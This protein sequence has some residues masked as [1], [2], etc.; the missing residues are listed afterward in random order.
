MSEQNT[1]DGTLIEV[2]FGSDHVQNTV[3]EQYRQLIADHDPEDVL[4]VAGSP[5]SM[6]T[7]ETLLGPELPGAAVPRVTSL[8]VHATD[9]INRTDDRA[10]L[11]DAMRRELVH[12]FLDDRD[13]ESDYL[14]RAAEQDSFEADFAQLMETAVWQ[15][16]EF[17]TTP[18]LRAVTGAVDEFHAWLDEHDHLERGELITKALTALSDDDTDDS[19]HDGEAV[20]VVE[21]EEFLEQ[22][23]EYLEAL[24]ADRQLVCIAERDASIRRAWVEPGPITERVS[25]T[26]ER[27]VEGSSPETRPGATARYLACEESGSDPGE[28]GV[29]VIAA[30]TANAEIERIA[31]EIERLRD[32]RGWEYEQF[33][34]A[35]KR[36][37][38][39][40]IDTLRELKQ[41]GIPTESATVVGFGDDPAIRELLQVVRALAETDDDGPAITVT[42]QPLDADRREELA[43]MDDLGDALRR[44][45]TASNL[46]QRIAEGTD[47]LEARTRFGNV[48]RAF[49]MA[50]F[51]E[52]TA[53]LEASWASFARMLERAHEYAPQHNQTSAIEQDGGVRVDH[54]RSLKNG[55]FEAVFVTNVVDA[56]YPGEPMVS[57]L[58][59]RERV[60]SMPDYPGVTQVTGEDVA[61]SFT[62]ESTASADPFRRYHAEY[63][64]RQLAVG[65]SVANSQLY[66][67]LHEHADTALDERVQPSRFLADA[68]RELPW[69]GETED[70]AIRTER[71]AEAYLLSRVDRALADV[72]RTNS[73]DIT[74]ALDDVEADLADIDALLAE[75][76]TR[77]D[78][79]REALR[80]R[81]DFATGRVRRE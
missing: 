1:Y 51:V 52:E 26:E 36:S 53:F 41:A 18:E 27:T 75:S 76:G 5:T 23:R 3:L 22:D 37:G 17:D 25:F 74:V 10:I 8:I 4:V 80:A 33:A 65:A 16:L 44:W 39:P 30:D 46:K 48:S 69:L 12:R 42:E 78:Q 31:D 68:Y 6:T 13:W 56:E 77:G 58:F 55:S 11:S 66:L 61:S 2:P 19:V 62:T 67:C 50:D 34:V 72:R 60:T 70:S 24:A 71:A 15:D 73:Q 28:G 47:P 20:L 7:F 81:V 45:A 14:R 64:R 59:P 21:F 63:A 40:V 57:R 38:Q 32:E 54:L 29:E 9:V 79:L 35:L 43:A 49:N